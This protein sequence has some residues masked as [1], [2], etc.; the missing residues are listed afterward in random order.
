MV[1]GPYNLL[2]GSLDPEG[3]ASSPP[4][5]PS[6]HTEHGAMD[7]WGFPQIRGAI[8]GVLLYKDK[9]ILGSIS[10]SPYFGKLPY[11]P[12]LKVQISFN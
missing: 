7:I 8:L 1:L 4:E 9:S 10:G 6:F 11:D 3:K 5:E 2:F 12:D